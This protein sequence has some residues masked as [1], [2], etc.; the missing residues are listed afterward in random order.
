MPASALK[1]RMKASSVKLVQ[2]MGNVTIMH[3]PA[4]QANPHRFEKNNRKEEDKKIG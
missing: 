2:K 4:E 1:A 3:C